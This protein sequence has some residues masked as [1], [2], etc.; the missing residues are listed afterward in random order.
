MEKVN[1]LRRHRLLLRKL[2]PA[3]TALFVA[4]VPFIAPGQQQDK[5]MS[6]PAPSSYPSLVE[7]ADSIM[8]PM[9]A[10]LTVPQSYEDL[11]SDELGYDLSTP[12]NIVTTADYD[13]VSGN[14]IVRTR[15]GD[16]DIATPFMLTPTQYNNWQFRK[17]M[18][19]Y[20]QQR[21]LA[22]ITEKEKQPFNILDM[23]FALGPL[24]KI[25]GPGGVQ[26]KTQG[27]VQV[28]MGIKSNKTD[29]PALPLSAR[30]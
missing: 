23:N 29:N 20:Y 5:R 2:L 10:S 7:Q 13:P 6:P 15:V 14:Y 19:K 27:T 12:S 1:A 9:G 26:L 25:F 18:Q 3:A 21:N 8:L 16:Y 17:S 24:E 4:L 28:A 22:Q 30:R 11:M